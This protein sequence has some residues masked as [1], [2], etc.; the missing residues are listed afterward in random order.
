MDEKTKNELMK[1]RAMA[2]TVIEKIDD[3][4]PRG[5]QKQKRCRL[6]EKKKASILTHRRLIRLG[7]V[8]H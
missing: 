1:I 8:S 7:N 2:E 4:I 5:E 3:L 6:S